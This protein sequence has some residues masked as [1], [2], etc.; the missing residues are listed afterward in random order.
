MRLRD[1]PIKSLVNIYL[2]VYI[3]MHPRVVIVMEDLQCSDG[4]TALQSQSGGSW[5]I[6]P[7]S[8]H[9]VSFPTSK[10][11]LGCPV[12]KH[13][14]SSAGF[15]IKPFTQ[16]RFYGSWSVQ[17]DVLHGFHNKRTLLV[18]FVLLLLKACTGEFHLMWLLF[19]GVHQ[20]LKACTG[21]G[22][23]HLMMLLVLL[24]WKHLLGRSIWRGWTG[25]SQLPGSGPL[26]LGTWPGWSGCQRVRSDALQPFGC[27]C[28]CVVESSG[29]YFKY[30]ETSRIVQMWS[31]CS[32]IPF[33][34]EGCKLSIFKY[35][36]QHTYVQWWSRC[37]TA[38]EE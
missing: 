14:V 36:D 20:R 15:K 21:D 9:P 31:S 22:E 4:C 28:T 3:C 33:K 18:L 26:R 1:C 10:L 37:S 16:R 11:N 7:I 6:G 5:L 8:K 25:P 30:C 34:E 38:L 24:G 35:R 27:P 2:I 13:L 29:E 23:I 17:R 32:G 12:S 19:L